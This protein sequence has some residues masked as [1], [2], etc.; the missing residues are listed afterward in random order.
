MACSRPARAYARGIIMCAM[1]DLPKDLAVSDLIAEVVEGWGFPVTNAEYIAVGYGSYHWVVTNA[2]GD[3][4]FLCVDDLDQKGFLGPNRDAAF[5]G[6]TCAFD[7]ALALR[8]VAGLEFVLAPEPAHA[9]DTVHRLGARHTVAVFPFLEGDAGSFDE[10]PN[11]DVRAATVSLLVRLHEATPSVATVSRPSQLQ[12]AARGGLESALQ[13]LNQE[14]PDGPLSESARGLV[15]RNADSVVRLLGEFDRLVEEVVAADSP[16][17]ITHGEPHGGNVM[18]TSTGYVL[19]DWDTT[20]LAPPERD[21]WIV[22]SGTGSELRQYTE[23]TGRA[24]NESALALYRLMWQLDDISG[25]TGQLR[26]E[27]DRSPD[28]EHALLWLG[29]SLVGATGPE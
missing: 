3:R 23:A 21:L 14:W 20:G 27:H 11:P 24:I 4:R 8:R 5:E 18:R 29:R 1:K 19:L 25:F 2:R 9:G 15:A 16:F 17:V 22:D 7:T 26:S 12:L 28:T 6:L 10:R 13:E